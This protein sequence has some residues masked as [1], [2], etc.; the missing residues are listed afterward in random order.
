MLRRYYELLGLTKKKITARLIVAKEFRCSE[1]S[2]RK[3]L[4]RNRDMDFSKKSGDTCG[5]EEE[6]V[7][8]HGQPYGRAGP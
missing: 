5:I 3:A 6:S 1:E 7:R 8:R 2:V 4:K